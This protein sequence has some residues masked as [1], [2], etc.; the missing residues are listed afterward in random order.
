MSGEAVE[1]IAGTLPADLEARGRARLYALKSQG[2]GEP[3]LS[4]VPCRVS[5]KNL[6]EWKR[7]WD[8]G[9][10]GAWTR[11]ILSNLR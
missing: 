9:T 1:V 3:E 10:I 11:R 6:A 4:E 2:F 8:D 5:A 7:W